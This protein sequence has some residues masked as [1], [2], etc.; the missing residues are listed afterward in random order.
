MA[1][2]RR[3]MAERHVQEGRRTVERQRELVARQ[4]AF[5]HDTTASETLLGQFER[6]L[7]GFE[8][9][10]DSIRKE[11]LIMSPPRFA[12]SIPSAAILGFDMAAM[13][14]CAAA[15]SLRSQSPI[16]NAGNA[17]QQ[18]AG[19]P[20]VFARSI[21]PAAATF[22]TYWRGPI[23]LITRCRSAS[24]NGLRITGRP[25]GSDSWPDIRTIFNP[26]RI[27]FARSAT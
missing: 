16:D 14:R 5:G 4:K 15:R 10:L 7:A 1:E 6:T 23:W 27:C 17:P 2:S 21:V 9:H 22:S 12:V 13:A 11:T 3:A 24:K 19:V 8:E 20:C 26:A 18:H 25:S